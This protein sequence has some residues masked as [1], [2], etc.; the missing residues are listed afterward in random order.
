M[1]MLPAY[2]ELRIEARIDP[3][4]MG[5]VEVGLPATVKMSTG[6]S[7]RHGGLDRR[8]VR[9][10]AD[11]ST[12]GMRRPGFRVLVETGRRAPGED[13]NRPITTGMPGS[14][15]VHTGHHGSPGVS[16]PVPKMRHEAFRERGEALKPGRRIVRSGG[17]RGAGPYR[18]HRPPRPGA[19]RAACAGVPGSGAPGLG[20][21]RGGRREYAARG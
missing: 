15:D 4:D 12:E 16:G 18:A 7:T 5:P 8:P 13:G 20:R 2:D 6:D 14:I 19:E 10:A 1:E 9:I 17:R 11:T 21:G 3:R